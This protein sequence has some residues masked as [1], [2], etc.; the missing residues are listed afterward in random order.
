MQEE[1]KLKRQQ[2]GWRVLFVTALAWTAWVSLSPVS[3]LPQINVWDKF[4]HATTYAALT[5]LLLNGW[6][7]LRTVVA[8]GAVMAFGIA[9]ECAQAAGGHRQGDWHDALANLVGIVAAIA[10]WQLLRWLHRRAY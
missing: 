3:E 2:L 7:R 8:G 4:A 1:R 9:I 10:V 6:P 5:F